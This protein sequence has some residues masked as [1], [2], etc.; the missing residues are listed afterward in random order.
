MVISKAQELSKSQTSDVE[1]T[2][3]NHTSQL[4]GELIETKEELIKESLESLV[5]KMPA[6]LTKQP[7]KMMQQ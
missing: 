7:N 5:N 3:E 2:D 4:S 1:M 6:K